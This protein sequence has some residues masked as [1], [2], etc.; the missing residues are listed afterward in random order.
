[1]VAKIAKN[2]TFMFTKVPFRHQTKSLAMA[3]ANRLV[4]EFQEPFAVLRCVDILG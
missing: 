2:S 1:V 4:E 3:E